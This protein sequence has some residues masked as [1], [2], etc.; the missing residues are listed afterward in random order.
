M[1]LYFLINLFESGMSTIFCKQLAKKTTIRTHKVQ[2]VGVLF[3]AANL[4]VM[5]AGSIPNSCCKLATFF[6]ADC[7]H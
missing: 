7:I 3:K 6:V 4:N 5:A 1:F 2:Y